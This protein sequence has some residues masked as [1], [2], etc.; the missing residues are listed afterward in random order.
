MSTESLNSLAGDDEGELD[1]IQ[2]ICK[3]G[4]FLRQI[5]RILRRLHFILLQFQQ[6]HITTSKEI[7][8]LREVLFPSILCAIVHSG[9]QISSILCVLFYGT[10][11]YHFFSF[12]FRSTRNAI[13]NLENKIRS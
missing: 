7:A 1:L 3:V 6:L 13:G 2:A 10:Y 5:I 12:S 9:N 11:Y 8:G 4:T